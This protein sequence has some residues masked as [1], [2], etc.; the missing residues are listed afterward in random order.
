MSQKI[1]KTDN[2]LDL[3]PVIKRN[4]SW[5]KK[6]NGLIEII[7]PRNKILDRIVRIFHKT[8][9]VMRIELDKVGSCVWKNIDGKKNIEE[10]GKILKAEFGQEVEP[11]YQRLG[12]YINILKNNK[13]IVLKK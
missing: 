7:I 2:F 12:T 8:P 9:K 6:E 3:I 4:Q 5:I 10:I 1:K 11:L 13:F